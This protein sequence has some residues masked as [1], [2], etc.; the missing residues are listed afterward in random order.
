MS[1]TPVQQRSWWGYGIAAVYTTFALATIGFAAFAFTQKVELVD[2]NYYSKSVSYQD[3]VQRL[4]NSTELG[5]NVECRVEDDKN[6]AVIVF[7]QASATGTI[8]LYR[9]SESGM[10]R[11]I[12]IQ[13]D[14]SG[15]QRITLTG[16]K[17]GKWIVKCAW[18]SGGVAYY[19]EQGIEV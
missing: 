5:K 13:P 16:L 14:G 9:P 12:D 15:R 1:T 4:S 6:S 17:R 2:D 19:Y 18:Q 11:T 3:H 7:P 10:D 8:T